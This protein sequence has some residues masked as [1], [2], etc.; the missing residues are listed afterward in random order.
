MGRYAEDTTVRA[1]WWDEGETATFQGSP[2]F[3]ATQRALLYLGQAQDIPIPAKTEEELARAGSAYPR[4]V[5]ALMAGWTLK[6]RDGQSVPPTEDAIADLP[7]K[8]LLY[9]YGEAA[10]VVMALATDFLPDAEI[11]PTAAAEGLTPATFPD[12]GATAGDIPR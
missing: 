3:L 2:G 12:T 7:L 5:L 1:D 10:K 4:L 11:T 8:D 9:L 6:G